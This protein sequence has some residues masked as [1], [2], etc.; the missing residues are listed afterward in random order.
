MTSKL[1][2]IYY[3]L[4]S[5]E[6]KPYYPNDQIVSPKE[7]ERQISYFR[8]KYDILPLNQAIKQYKEGIS[9]DRQMVI[10]TDD[11]FKE[12][13]TYIAPILDQLNCKATFFVND[14]TI[15]NQSMMWRHILFYI[16]KTASPK[17]ILPAIQKLQQKY[18]LDP[19]QPSQSLLSWSLKS[20]PMSVKEAFCIDLW[21]EIKNES[22]ESYL[23]QNKIYLTAPDLK[24][25]VSHGYDIG[26]HTKTHPNCD[27]LNDEEIKEEIILSKERL[28]ELTNMPI[29]SFSF[30]FGRSK[31]VTD[32]LEK[33]NIFEAV[34]G[35]NDRMK[36]TDSPIHWERFCCDFP[37]YKTLLHFKVN[38]VK[39]FLNK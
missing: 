20:I 18:S 22:I 17:A 19:I 13:H 34:L 7:F 11:G 30:P 37:Y 3:H 28:S 4:V 32:K 38:N 26:C 24:E 1:Q 6:L 14:A 36:T 39:R 29:T 33:E 35:T 5:E 23:E 27:L 15:D 8:K 12:N 21:F 2:I 25:L 9:F 10:T 16:D 31:K